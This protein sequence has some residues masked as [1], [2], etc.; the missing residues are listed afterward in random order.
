[1]ALDG[2]ASSDDDGTTVSY[3]W[4]PGGLAGAV[5]KPV[6]SL[7]THTFTLTVKDNDGDEDTDTLRS[8][9]RAV[10]RRFS[11][12]YDHPRLFP[13]YTDPVLHRFFAWPI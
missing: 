9:R 11:P 7:G 2:S 3:T 13:C 6:L 4:E 5:V 8:V 10:Y 12:D 1:M